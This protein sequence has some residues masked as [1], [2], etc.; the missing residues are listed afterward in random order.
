ML[1]NTEYFRVGNVVKVI[2]YVGAETGKIFR[3]QNYLFS[4]YN[5]PGDNPNKIIFRSLEISMTNTY[6]KHNETVWVVVDLDKF[7]IVTEGATLD[8]S[9]IQIGEKG[10]E[11]TVYMN[12]ED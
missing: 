9:S 5:A 8:I 7:N 4:E 1:V 2:P 10:N 12:W 11:V 3:I 6:F